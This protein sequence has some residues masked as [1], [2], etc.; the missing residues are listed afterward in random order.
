MFIFIYVYIFILYI[1]YYYIIYTQEMPTLN[2]RVQI[3]M[4]KKTQN[5]LKLQIFLL[6]SEAL[7]MYHL[8]T[9]TY[10]CVEWITKHT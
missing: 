1:Y 2:V 5:L 6:F 3:Y 10:I 8:H 4:N 9:H 7:S